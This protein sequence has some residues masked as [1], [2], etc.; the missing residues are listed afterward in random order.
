MLRPYLLAIQLIALA[1]REL[2]N[3]IT[4]LKM[5]RQAAIDF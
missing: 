2:E 1:E 4:R 5:K 3:A